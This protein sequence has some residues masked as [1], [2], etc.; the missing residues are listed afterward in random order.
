MEEAL[1]SERSQSGFKSLGVYQGLFI[2]REYGS[3][4]SC[5]DGIDTRTD[6]VEW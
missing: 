5:S 3:L 1:R 2:Y 6:R 4:S